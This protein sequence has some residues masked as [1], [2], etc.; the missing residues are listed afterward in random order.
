MGPW[1]DL[2]PEISLSLVVET[3]RTEKLANIVREDDAISS[4]IP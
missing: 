4:L 2:N 3:P 1:S